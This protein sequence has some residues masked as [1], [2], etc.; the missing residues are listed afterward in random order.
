MSNLTSEVLY[1]ESTRP[2]SEVSESEKEQKV[3][4][5][6]GAQAVVQLSQELSFA[7]IFTGRVLINADSIIYDRSGVQVDTA[8]LLTYLETE[9]EV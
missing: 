4:K 9:V 7:D 1:V 8:E 3:S 6:L 5:Y 2:Y